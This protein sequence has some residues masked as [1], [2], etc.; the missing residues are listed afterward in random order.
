MREVCGAIRTDATTGSER[1]RGRK[2][3]R[4][5]VAPRDSDTSPVTA[6]ARPCDRR[7]GDRDAGSHDVLM[8][9]GAA[10]VLTSTRIATIC[11]SRQTGQVRSETPVRASTR[12][13]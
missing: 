4:L 9:A 10:H 8:T 7:D 11:P 3:V 5:L 13:R 6:R 1:R 12:S 2:S